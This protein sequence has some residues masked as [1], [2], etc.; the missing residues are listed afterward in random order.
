MKPINFKEAT[1]VLQRPSTMTDAECASLHVWSDGKQCV[2]YIET[3]CL[4]KSENPFRWQ[5]VPWG[6]RWW[7]ATAGV[8]YRGK[9][10]QPIVGNCKHH[11]VSWRC[12]SLYRN[13]NQDGVEQHQ[14]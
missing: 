1:K 7:N 5:S 2:S 12:G 14:R 3:F 6:Q 8:C 9:P 10:F 11:R 4:G 13:R